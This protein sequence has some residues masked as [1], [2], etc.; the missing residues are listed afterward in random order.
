MYYKI[1]KKLHNTQ[2]EY[3]NTLDTWVQIKPQISQGLY[4]AH[5]SFNIHL[6][7]FEAI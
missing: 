6:T 1:Q 3:K 2:I 4:N 5:L 7:E